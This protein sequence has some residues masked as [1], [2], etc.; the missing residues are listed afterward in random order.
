MT[1]MAAGAD[2]ASP[3]GGEEQISGK[4]VGEERG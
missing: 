4:P 1:S 3:E 2:V